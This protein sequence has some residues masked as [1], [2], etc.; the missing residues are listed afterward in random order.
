M[1][2]GISEPQ[3]IEHEAAHIRMKKIASMFV[4]NAKKNFDKEFDFSATSLELLDEIIEKEWGGKEAPNHVIAAFGA[5][6][7]EIIKGQSRGRWVSGITEQDPATI[8]Y[9][10]KNEDAESINISPFMIIRDKFAN[11]DKYSISTAFIAV[12]QTL[13]SEKLA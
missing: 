6:L 1:I 5:Y 9:L 11:P 12:I 7:G 3:L 10:P 4:A 13:K 8:M 2:N